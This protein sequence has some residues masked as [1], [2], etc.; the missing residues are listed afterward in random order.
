MSD[1]MPDSV[2]VCVNIIAHAVNE[3]GSMYPGIEKIRLKE[4]LDLAEHA[5]KLHEEKVG[6]LR[7][8]LDGVIKE[9][10][11]IKKGI[12]ALCSESL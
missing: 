3:L 2:E 1:N 7:A 5:E 10:H 8:E 12:R 4:I 11:E 6:E 9:N